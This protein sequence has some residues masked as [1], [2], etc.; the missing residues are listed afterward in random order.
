MARFARALGD[1]RVWARGLARVELLRFA[2]E[3][4]ASEGEGTKGRA[5]QRTSG[6][7]HSRPPTLSLP[8]RQPRSD[9]GPPPSYKTQSIA[10]CP[11]ALSGTTVRALRVQGS[12]AIGGLNAHGCALGLFPLRDRI[13]CLVPA[14]SASAPRA[15]ASG[16]SAFRSS[17]RS[18]RPPR[19]RRACGRG[20]LRGSLADHSRSRVGGG[21]WRGGVWRGRG[22]RRLG[23]RVRRFGRRRCRP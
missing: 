22:G 9:A 19:R 6:C 11:P 7:H 3:H 4:A 20:Q 5:P 8:L 13:P 2:A 14:P 12:G 15:P 1:V 17:R 23:C 18:A 10:T 21:W 16:I